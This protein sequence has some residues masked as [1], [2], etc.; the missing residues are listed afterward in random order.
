MAPKLA[1]RLWVLFMAA[2]LLAG[3]G[4]W[5]QQQQAWQRR[6]AQE[7]CLKRRSAI[8]QQLALIRSGQQALRAMA[9]QIYRPT[10]KPKPLDPQLASR[11]SQLDRQLDEERYGAALTAWRLDEQQ[12]RKRWQRSQRERRQRLEA[13]L[14]RHLVALAG[15]DPGLVSSGQPD[16]AE[17]AR[18]SDCGAPV[19]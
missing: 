13:Q 6:Q 16:L 5:W 7:R 2:L 8:E 17:I 4:T 18:L 19:R 3:C 11:F 12:R 1:P 10:P 15:V 14:N 9:A